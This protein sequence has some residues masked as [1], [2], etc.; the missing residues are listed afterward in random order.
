M[1]GRSGFLATC[2]AATLRESGVPLLAVGR[3]EIDLTVSRSVD[4]LSDL[5]QRDD[6]VVILSALTPDK[7]RNVRTLMNNVRMAEHLC[8]VFE[9]RSCAHV[10]YI[11]SDAVYDGRDTPLTEDSN[12]QPADL[13][14][15]M[16]TSRE[17]MLQSALGA[18]NIPYCFLRPVAL[19]GAGDTHNSY[20]PNRFIRE[21]FEARTITLFGKGHDERSHLYVGD[22][23]RLVHRCIKAVSTGTLNLAA[24][25]TISFLQV[26]E[27]IRNAMPFDTELRFKEQGNAG[28]SRRPYDIR[29]L[30]AAFPDFEFTAFKSAID[31][32][33]AVLRVDKLAPS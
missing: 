9:R 18:G 33:I 24:A 25:E 20:G 30:R 8:E 3:P 26:A 6:T 13:Y 16:H 19:F 15:L 7:G 11:S 31:A 32:F 5:L 1:I 14:A 28:G 27:M 29:N 21:A 10:L 23:A 4:A 12:R 2:L 22:A 17:M